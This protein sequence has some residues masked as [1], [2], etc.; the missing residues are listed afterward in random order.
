MGE[1]KEIV[2]EKKGK[3]FDFSKPKQ[4]D[5][6]PLGVIERLAGMI[7]D[8]DRAIEVKQHDL[9]V[10]GTSQAPEN[11]FKLG[12]LRAADS[13]LRRAQAAL[14]DYG[15]DLS[16]DLDPT[17]DED[18]ASGDDFEHDPYDPSGMREDDLDDEDK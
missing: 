10:E 12:I 13:L 1:A 3:V 8:L 11:H 6:S 9:E 15:S 17:E 14:E 16:Q 5:K 4:G 18:A 2:G 7:E